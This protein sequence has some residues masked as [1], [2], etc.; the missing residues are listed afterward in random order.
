MPAYLQ[1][2]GDGRPV[3]LDKPILFVGRHPECDI[4]LLNSRKVSRKHCCLALVNDRL[5]VRDLGSTNGVSVNGERVKKE[6]QVKIGD[7]LTIGDVAYRLMKGN[8]PEGN[9]GNNGEQL[10]QDEKVVIDG[11]DAASLKTFDDSESDIVLSPKSLDLSQDV[12]VIIEEDSLESFSHLDLVKPLPPKPSA[13]DI[14]EFDEDSNA[15]I[16]MLDDSR[17]FIESSSDIESK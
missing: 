8:V 4:V 1:P 11:K 3:C 12:P 17:E 15:D 5:R 9:K 10:S 6:A 2:L 7:E 14:E 13:D 16:I